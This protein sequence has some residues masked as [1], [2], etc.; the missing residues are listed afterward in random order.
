[1]HVAVSPT[2]EADALEVGRE[3]LLNEAMNVV[4]ALGYTVEDLPHAWRFSGQGDALVLE[5]PAT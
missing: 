2:I 4:E 5:V 3:V 1:M